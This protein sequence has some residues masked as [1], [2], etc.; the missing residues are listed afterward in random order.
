MAIE[1]RIYKVIT[2]VQDISCAMRVVSAINQDE[3]FPITA[4]S[5]VAYVADNGQPVYAERAE[6]SGNQK[7]LYGYYATD[8]FDGITAAEIVFLAGTVELAF[9]EVPNLQ[10]LIEPDLFASTG[11]P[12][13]TTAWLQT[14]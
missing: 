4:Q 9:I 5:I 3:L 6:L 1:F 10:D 8:A 13:A 11:Y 14:I 2:T 12:D 7:E